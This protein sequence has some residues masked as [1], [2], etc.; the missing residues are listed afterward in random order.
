MD[1]KSHKDLELYKKSMDFV[2]KI[3]HVTNSFPQEEKYGLT[4][5]I[6]R[7]V[8]SIPSNISEGAARK[9]TKEFIQF[10]YV[11]LGSAAEVETQL[12]LSHRLNFIAK[13][14]QIDSELNTIIRM[15]TGLISLLKS[16]T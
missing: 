10:L 2:E 14:S 6:R 1:V 8:V 15:L 12:D 11:A 7:A 13:N 4:S 5:Q 3:Y 16:K 9:N